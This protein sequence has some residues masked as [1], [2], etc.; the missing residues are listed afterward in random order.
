VG[1]PTAPLSGAGRGLGDL[2]G[3]TRCV[4][5]GDTIAG[6]DFAAVVPDIA[7]GTRAA[8]AWVLERGRRAA[9][10]AWHLATPQREQAFLGYTDALRAAG[11]PAAADLV[12][13]APPT[14]E[15]GYKQVQR[16]ADLD[17]PISGVVVGHPLMS[18]GA[19]DMWHALGGP[20]AFALAGVGPEGYGGLPAQAGMITVPAYE[21][22]R[23]AVEMLAAAQGGVSAGVVRLPVRFIPPVGDNGGDAV[24]GDLSA[25]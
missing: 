9:F 19:M 16:L 17:P 12:C 22:G 23:R 4:L 15:G 1:V 6:A 7:A 13:T 2:P 24:R 5:I 18:V 8:T 25:V 10:V 20:R 21:M 14:P 3:Q 11:V